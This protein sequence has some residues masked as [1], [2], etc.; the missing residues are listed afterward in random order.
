MRDIPFVRRSQRNEARRRELK[1]L[2][3]QSDH[4]LA[5]NTPIANHFRIA[6]RY[7]RIE[8]A[9]L[10]IPHGFDM[11]ATNKKGRPVVEFVND[12][13]KK[14]RFVLC[15][16]GTLRH[17]GSD[18][19]KQIVTVVAE[20]VGAEIMKVDRVLVSDRTYED[21]V[22]DSKNANRTY[23]DALMDVRKPGGGRN[24]DLE[25]MVKEGFAKAEC[26]VLNKEYDP[27]NH[28]P[29]TG[30][31]LETPGEARRRYAQKQVVVCGEPRWGVS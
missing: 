1:R 14:E 15:I 5:P 31:E 4:V 16:D 17:V 8:R 13:G 3:A 9:G 6:K 28:M 23:E 24:G 11:V 20:T 26:I 29:S 21:A 27:L 7:P 12:D 19:L 2:D 18:P 25:K 30:E 22:A 10:R